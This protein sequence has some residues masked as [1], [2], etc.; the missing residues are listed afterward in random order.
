MES[1]KKL[2]K[3]QKQAVLNTRGPLLV[4]AGAGTGKTK[5]ITHRI[6]YIIN[7]GVDPRCI[8]A[9]TFTNKAAQEMKERIIDLNSTPGFGVADL[10]PTIGTFHGISADIL[11]K[12]GNHIGITDHFLILNERECL[13]IIKSAIEELG[14]DQRQFRPNSIQNLIS[15]KKSIFNGNNSSSGAAE[16]ASVP[17]SG[18]TADMDFFPK[19]FNLIWRKY[20]ERLKERNGLD[21]DDLILKTIELFEN[22][23]EILQIYQEKWPYI[24]IDEYQD[25]DPS[26][27]RLIY[28]LCQKHGNIC[29]VGDEDQSIY[30]FRGADF[31]NILNFEKNWPDAKIVTLERNYRSSQKI[32]DAANAIIS[33]NIMRREKNLYS[34]NKKGL[35]LIIREFKN[36]TSEAEFIAEE[37]KTLLQETLTFPIAVL[38]RL[39]SQFPAFE[40]AFSKN[41]LPYQSASQQDDLM[42]EKRPIRLMTVHA[43]KGLEFKNVFIPGLEKGLFPYSNN[44]EERRLF[45][46]ALT[47]SQEKIFLS[48]CRYRNAFGSKQINQPSQ[49][50]SDIPKNLLKWL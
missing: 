31:A 5:V 12:Y 26:Q 14:L 41:S 10:T 22:K 4:V 21:F 32:L 25:T 8:L 34:R 20:H 7:Q 50:L 9:V 33:K 37:I 47:R 42:K 17:L 1:L 23:P 3:Q 38:C 30:G 36:E 6:A 13:D 15:Q 46:V 2:N 49:F 24:H 44:E 18:T 39:N 40:E 45:Y 43:A 35:P 27:A 28:L 19:N 48:F 29:A 11:R 16:S